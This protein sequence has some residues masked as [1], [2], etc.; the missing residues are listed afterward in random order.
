MKISAYTT[1]QNKP[2]IKEIGK[3]ENGWRNKGQYANGLG[4]VI[5]GE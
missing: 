2:A 1:R 3:L 5:N 4:G